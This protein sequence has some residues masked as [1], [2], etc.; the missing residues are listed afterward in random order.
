MVSGSSFVVPVS[1]TGQAL[2]QPTAT[3]QPCKCSLN[4]PSSRQHL[5]LMAVSRTPHNLQRP[6][7][8]GHDPINQ[9]ACVT[10]ISPDQS[11]AR[12]PSLQF[13]NNQLCTI[14]VLD[15]SGVD[16]DCQ[17][18]SYSVHD[19]MP[20]AAR[21]LLT[22]IITTRP[23][24]SVVFTLWLSMI[25]ALGLVCRPSA[26]RTLSRRASWTLSQVPSF[27]QVRK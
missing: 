26:V 19:D 10:S 15:V 23:P 5:E 12:E 7:R 8:Q 20:L 16:H 2:A 9:L 13:A 14:S 24:F 1:S 21:H 6:T 27:R 3:S 17:Q 18:Q 25:A 22:G 11:Q 4:H